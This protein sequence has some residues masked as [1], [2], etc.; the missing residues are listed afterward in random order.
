MCHRTEHLQGNLWLRLLLNSLCVDMHALCDFHTMYTIKKLVLTTTHL[1]ARHDTFRC[2]C[3]VFVRC[4]PPALLAARSVRHLFYSSCS[5]LIKAR[6]TN[7]NRCW[8]QRL[9]RKRF[10]IA[11]MGKMHVYRLMCHYNRGDAA[12]PSLPH[13]A[14]ATLSAT[15]RRWPVVCISGLLFR[16]SA[17]W[18]DLSRWDLGRGPARTLIICVIWSGLTE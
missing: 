18:F 7:R 6:K 2:C 3:C 5:H 1:T 12:I 4:V 15:D 13:L 17:S 11:E 16:H 9:H 10:I 14:L 8:P